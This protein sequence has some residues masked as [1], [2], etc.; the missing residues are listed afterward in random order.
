MRQAWLLVLLCSALCSPRSLA[1]DDRYSAYAGLLQRHVEWTQQGR[2]SAVDYAGLQTERGRL[3]AVLVEF[4]AVSRVEFEA[5]SARQQ[6]AFL[7]NAYN[8]YTLELVLGRY[9][10]LKSIKDLG[11][12]F[13]SPWKQKFFRLLGEE[14]TLDWIE[15][16]VLR[17]RYRDPRIHFAINCASVGCPALRPEPYRA[18]LLDVQLDDG[19]RR[20]LGD[21]RRNRFDAAS[22]VLRL[23]PIFKW[24]G[25]DFEAGAG[26]SLR[27]WLAAR[28]N[29]L[30]EDESARARLRAGEFR[31]DFG[32]YDWSLN[33]L[34]R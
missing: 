26:G 20:F 11:G 34:R 24:F 1:L 29:Q 2:A 16:E 4:S 33:A 6:Q 3:Q 22:G 7:I 30:A 25:E 12:L 31:I 5:W 19:Q 8:A 9:P 10:A 32:D 15:H 17:P 23:S 27:A 18:E 14:R 13:S 21:R 28:A